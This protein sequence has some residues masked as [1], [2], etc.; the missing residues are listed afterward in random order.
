[1]VHALMRKIFVKFYSIVWNVNNLKFGAYFN[2]KRFKI[3]L[4][5]QNA[6]WK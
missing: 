1:M 5:I 3:L 2:K 4:M 6:G